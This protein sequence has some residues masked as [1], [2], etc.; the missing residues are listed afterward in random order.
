[1]LLYDESSKATAH[2]SPDDGGGDTLHHHNPVSDLV[3]TVYLVLH[4]KVSP[5]KG[6]HGGV[7]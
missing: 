7:P 4:P 6:V 3:Y 1:M 5:R 2:H